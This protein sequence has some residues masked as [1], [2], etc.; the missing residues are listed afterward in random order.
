MRAYATLARIRRH[1]AAR[2]NSSV[3]RRKRGTMSALRFPEHFPPK[4]RWGKFFIGV[5]WLGP[6]LS[7]F[8][9]LKTAQAQRAAQELTAW[10][11]G[12]RQTLAHAISRVLAR[13]LGWK[14][15]V[16]LP[17]NSAAVVFHGPRYDFSDPESAFAEVVEMLAI[18]FRIVVPESFWARYAEASFGE[19]IDA[20]LNERA[21]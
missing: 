15:D 4:D 17:E 5:R 9:T 6:D 7:F 11:G 2:L 10:G 16:F 14:S 1:Y 8:K 19:I 12:A 21:A 13:S 3:R 20:L 18:D